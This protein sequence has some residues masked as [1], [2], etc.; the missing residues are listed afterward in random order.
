[1]ASR[2][3]ARS[4][5]AL[6]GMAAAC[7]PSPGTGVNIDGQEAPAIIASAREVVLLFPVDTF[8]DYPSVRHLVSYP[9]SVPGWELQVFLT[10]RSFIGAYFRLPWPD[11]TGVEPIPSLEDEVQRASLYSC[12]L[13][14]WLEACGGSLAG[15]ATIKQGRVVIRITDRR[16]V[17]NFNARRPAAGK[18]IAH[19]PV[20]KEGW[21]RAIRIRYVY[22][23]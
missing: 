10:D 19:R 2:A 17:R 12:T 15:A 11:S 21:S 3:G 6:V 1:M 18:L 14:S 13:D 8:N 23:D 16:W 9:F 22:R 4:L 20:S 7:V 5:Y